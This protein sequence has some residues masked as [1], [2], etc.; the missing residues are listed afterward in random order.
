MDEVLGEDEH[1][2][3][4]K[5]HFPCILV[6]ELEG[7]WT[8]ENDWPEIKTTQEFL[9][10]FEVSFHSILVDLLNIPLLDEEF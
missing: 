5:K 6:R 10:W 3:L 7:W 9:E 8:D 1:E 2:P 4:I